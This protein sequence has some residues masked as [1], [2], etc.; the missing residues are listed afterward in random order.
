MSEKMFFLEVMTVFQ[1]LVLQYLP[2]LQED[3]SVADFQSSEALHLDLHHL[4][5]HAG[6]VAY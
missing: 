3:L 4:R 6:D 1:V 5:L 2:F